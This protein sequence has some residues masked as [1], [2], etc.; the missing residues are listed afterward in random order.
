MLTLLKNIF[1]EEFALFKDK[2]NAKPPGG[3]GFYAHYDGIFSWIDHDGISRNGWYH[4]AKNFVNILV[5]IDPMNK[6]NG[7]LEI[8]AEHR[9][10]FEELLKNTKNNNT[11]DIHAS[12]E[13]RLDFKKIIIN[14]GDIVV[15]SNKC[16]HRSMRNSS[17]KDRRTIYYTYN[18]KSEGQHYD[19]YF[20][21]K[22]SS[23]NKT[24]KSLSGEI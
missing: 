4:Y 8:S 11:P 17:E 12:L 18:P 3:E 19:Q 5:A 10:S 14:S 1:S 7:P 6:N 2:Y 9:G 13:K 16:P 21:D 23:K 20:K 22:V 15:F 24:S